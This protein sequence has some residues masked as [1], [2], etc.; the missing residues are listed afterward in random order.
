MQR[1]QRKLE[2]IKYALELGDGPA[3]THFADIQF[4]HN[5][6]TEINQQN[7]DKYVKIQDKQ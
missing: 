5:C 2:H 4:I 6:L 7:R 3:T 1:E